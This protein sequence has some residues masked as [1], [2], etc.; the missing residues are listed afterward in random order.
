[1]K[2]IIDRPD[3]SRIKTLE[4]MSVELSPYM[5]EIEVDK[6]VEFMC[7]ISGSKFDINPSIEDSKTQLQIILGKDRYKEIEMKWTLANQ[8][9]ITPYGKRKYRSK[10]DPT[11][12]TL[13]D[14]LD[15]QDDPK[16]WEQIFV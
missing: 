4:R 15:P 7:T 13:Y 8:K 14:G 6:V 9:L 10:I 3:T 1:M 11:D 12:K 5:N 2:H 16:D